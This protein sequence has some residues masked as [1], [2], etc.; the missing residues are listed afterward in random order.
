MHVLDVLEIRHG[1]LPVDNP[2]IVRQR[3]VHH[4]SECDLSRV[5]RVPDGAF[6]DVVQAK[7]SRLRRVAIGAIKKPG[8]GPGL[9]VISF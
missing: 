7:D 4:R 9:Y 5:V 6:D 8:Q 3:D 2:V 1:A